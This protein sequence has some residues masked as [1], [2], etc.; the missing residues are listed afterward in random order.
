MRRHWG[1]INRHEA[2]I[3]PSVDRLF[4]IVQAIGDGK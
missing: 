2:V 4:A 3:A 1:P